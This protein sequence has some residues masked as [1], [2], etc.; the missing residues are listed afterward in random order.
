MLVSSLLLPLSKAGPPCRAVQDHY[1]HAL[2]HPTVQTSS[3]LTSGICNALNAQL[4]RLVGRSPILRGM[5][6]GRPQQLTF[7]QW[8][9]RLGLSTTEAANALGRSERQVQ[10]YQ[11]GADIPRVV[12]LAMLYLLEHPEELPQQQFP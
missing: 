12:G 11:A 6:R 4:L 5:R 3:R 9:E 7:P 10:Y 8:R 1:T 2:V